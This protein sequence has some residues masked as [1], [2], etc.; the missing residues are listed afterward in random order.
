M[1][2]V[3]E[4]CG[5]ISHLQTLSTFLDRFSFVPLESREHHRVLVANSTQNTDRGHWRYLYFRNGRDDF[6]QLD[7]TDGSDHHARAALQGLVST[8]DLDFGENA[9]A[10]VIMVHQSQIKIG[11]SCRFFAHDSLWCPILGSNAKTGMQEWSSQDSAGIV[12]AA[13]M[14]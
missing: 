3:Q 4:R 13:K 1:V 6:T 10:D 9:E 5:A 8:R 14:L 12:F 2:N 7:A 11:V